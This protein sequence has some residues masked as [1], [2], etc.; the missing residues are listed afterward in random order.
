MVGESSAARADRFGGNRALLRKQTNSDKTI[1]HFAVGLF[2]YEFVASE[3]APEI[4][5]GAGEEFAGDTAEKLNQ[6]MRVGAFRS[7]L[8]NAQK[9]VLKGIV[10][11]GMGPGFR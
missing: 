11:V 9:E 7:F 4:N 1:G 8:G 2:P 3:M 6:R 5:A 10:E